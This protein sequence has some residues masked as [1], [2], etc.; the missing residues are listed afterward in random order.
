MADLLGV[1]VSGLFAWVLWR[2]LYLFKLPSWSKR[3]KV[4]FDWA[5]DLVFS[6]DLGHLRTDQTERISRARYQPGDY[7]FRTGD[8]AVNF[9]AIERG[10]VD[11]IETREN[12]EER[13]LAVLGAG[14]FFGEMA[15]L[16]GRPHHASVRARSELVVF[17]MG[18][19]IFE[20]ISKSLTPLRNLVAEAVRRRGGHLWRHLPE[21]RATRRPP[22]TRGR[23]PPAAPSA[24]CSAPC[25][26]GPSSG[27]ARTCP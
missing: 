24:N 1:R 26:N 7:V 21:A 12:G 27:R 11:V 15:M 19:S 8:P 2:S 4:G 3:V 9:Y 25:R 14:D 20:R 23:A 17:V 16:E 22:A 10:E 13:P 6:R 18:C 5:W